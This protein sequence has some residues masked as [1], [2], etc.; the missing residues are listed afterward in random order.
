M[1]VLY[2]HK[3]E[4]LFM[5]RITNELKRQKRE[6]KRTNTA[7]TTKKT[8]NPYNK[9]SNNQNEA[10]QEDSNWKKPRV[11]SRQHWR[12]SENKRKKII[13]IFNG[14]KNPYA[15]ASREIVVRCTLH[16]TVVGVNLARALCTQTHTGI[17]DPEKKQKRSEDHRGCACMRGLQFHSLDLS[18]YW[19]GATGSCR[20]I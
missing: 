3:H 11:R 16:K 17:V 19:V 10:T 7:T 6:V 14:N 20:C 15:C 2:V 13:I 18:V 5:M 9:Q 4:L 8:A 12:K 1:S